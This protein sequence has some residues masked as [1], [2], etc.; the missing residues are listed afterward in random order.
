MTASDAL[1]ILI[2]NKLIKIWLKLVKKSLEEDDSKKASNFF[3]VSPT[4]TLN[5]VVII[6]PGDYELFSILPKIT[7][8]FSEKMNS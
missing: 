4:V 5:T 2:N 8:I 6:F 3:L 1:K 7:G